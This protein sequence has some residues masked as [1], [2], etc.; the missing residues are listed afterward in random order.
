M[1]DVVV[2]FL[3][4]IGLAGMALGASVRD[5]HAHMYVG[6]FSGAFLL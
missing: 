1:S 5:T 4:A 2:D 6:F 3:G